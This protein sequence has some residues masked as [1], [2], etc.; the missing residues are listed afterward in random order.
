MNSLGVRLA[1]HLRISSLSSSSHAVG[2]TRTGTQWYSTLLTESD[3]DEGLNDRVNDDRKNEELDDEFDD[4]L[5]SKP[6]LELQGVDPKRGW[7]FRGVHKAIICGKVGQVPVQ[8]ILRNGKNVTIFT[9]GTG[10]MSD[11]RITREVDMPRP[12]QWHRIAV[13]N[14]IL[15]AYAV[16]QL[17]KNSSVYV[18]GDIETRVYNDSINGEVKSIPEI[19]VRRDGKLRLI[20]GGES[21]DTNSLDELREGLF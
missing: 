10:G 6:D 17:S 4:F 15:G 9:V 11:Q 12:A 18:E 16:Q 5:G 20:K 8:K 13:H 14:H 7:G 1:K 2:M 19:C 3:N 21:I